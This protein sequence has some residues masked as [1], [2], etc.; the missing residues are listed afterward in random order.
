MH[1]DDL[2]LF[3]RQGL[4][5]DR[6]PDDV[7]YSICRELVCLVRKHVV[8]P[9]LVVPK[10]LPNGKFSD[11]RPEYSEI[12]QATKSRLS[13]DVLE[14]TEN[15][16]RSRKIEGG[17]VNNN[18]WRSVLGVLLGYLSRQ[19]RLPTLIVLHSLVLV[20]LILSTAPC[21]ARTTATADPIRVEAV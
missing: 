18:S 19:P 7:S 12:R 2:G 3:G 16:L 6:G 8:P 10:I 17:G 14:G 13:R 20:F 9:K 11:I 15:E 5:I 21:D 4:H 1:N